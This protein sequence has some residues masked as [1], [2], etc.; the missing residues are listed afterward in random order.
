[1]TAVELL[2][3]L[4]RRGFSM[5]REGDGIRVTPASRLTA[6]VRQEVR[7]HRAELLALLAGRQEPAFAWD[8]AEADHLLAQMRGALARAE[9]ATAAGEVPAVRVAAMRTWLEVGVAYVIDREREAARGY[10]ALALLRGA[11]ARAL[12]LAGLK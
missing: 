4:T 2:D 10:D 3:D 1:M 12:T 5:A 9:A 8:Q 6:D 7:A 11:V